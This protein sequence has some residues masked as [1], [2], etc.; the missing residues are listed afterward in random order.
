MG[1]EKCKI[2]DFGGKEFEFLE[3]TAPK[4]AGRYLDL[5]LKACEIRQRTKDVSRRNK[6]DE[7]K[8]T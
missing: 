8:N 1:N 4:Q 3:T 5:C 2:I 6:T 7:T